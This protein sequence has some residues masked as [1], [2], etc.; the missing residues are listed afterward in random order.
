[1][2]LSELLKNITT[3]PASA[4]CIISHISLDSR[5][6]NTRDL[7]IAIKG[8]QQDGRKFIADAVARGASAILIE[9]DTPNQAI[10]MQSGCLLIPVDK[11][12]GKIAQIAAQF[13]DHPSKK[14]RMIGVTG[15]NGKTSYSHFLAQILSAKKIPCGII[16]TLGSGFYNALGPVGLTTP[17]PIMLQAT[18]ADFVKQGAKAVAM[19]VS[20]HSIAQGR[21]G[22]IDF[23]IAAFTNLS[24]DHLDYHGT[25]EAYAAVKHQFVAEFPHKHLVINADD[26]YGKKWINELSKTKSIYA[27]TTHPPSSHSFVPMVYAEKTSFSLRGIEATVHSPWGKG[28]VMLSLIG[29]FN[30]SNALAVL[31][32]LCLYG[33]AFE[34]ALS[35]L[36]TLQP[37]PGRTQTLGGEDQPIVVVDYAHSPDA[38]EKVLHALRKHTRGQL[39]CVFG[40]GGERDQGKRPLMAKVVEQWADRFIVT[41]DNPRH[42]DPHTIAKQIVSGFTK[43]QQAVVNL[44]RSKAIENS[45][46]WASVGDCVLIAGKGAEHYQQIGDQKI[47]FDDVLEVKKFLEQK[48]LENLNATLDK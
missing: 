17:D 47:P 36:A 28:R 12:A 25:M 1:M 35:A 19:E 14:L 38:L 6:I 45:I 41:N 11:L 46:Q 2:R 48:R 21:I 15:T 13:Y 18:L 8:S 37:V 42:E 34:D 16:G 33:I 31:T 10:E 26:A 32:S 20:S 7:F 22:A 23:E 44:D 29:E 30:L 3:L 43:P 24:Q 40:C 9:A 39:I 4:D 27:F 5:K